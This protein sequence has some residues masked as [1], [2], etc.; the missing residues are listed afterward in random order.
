MTPTI[1]PRTP[2]AVSNITEPLGLSPNDLRRLTLTGGLP[3]F[4]GAGN[5]YSMHGIAE[6]AD[7]LRAT[8]GGYALVSANG[9]VL[10]KTSV[11]S[12]TG[13]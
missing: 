11:G 9:G 8:P 1:D 7:R 3:Y 5:N 6:A 13:R 10:S 12:E 4:G 2:I